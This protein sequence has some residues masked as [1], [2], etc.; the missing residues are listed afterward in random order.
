MRAYFSFFK[1][2]FLNGLQY[3][4][5]A[6]AG[7]ATQFAWGGMY[8]MLYQTFYKSNSAAAP[9]KFSQLSSYIWL[10][11]AFL[12]LF[13]TWFLD[14]DIFTLITNGNVAYELCRP[15]DLYHMWF[16]KNCG[17]RLSKTALRCFPILIVAF[18][19]PKPYKFNLPSSGVSAL[20]FILAMFLAFIVV[21]SYCM[22]V[23]IFT[24]YTI[25]PMG[26]RIALVMTADFLSGGL[27]PLP[28]LP[29]WLT[30]YLYL[31]PFAAMQ[32]V[33]FRVY[34]GQIHINEAATA[35]GLQF[36]WAVVLIFLGKFI[37][38]KALNRV[39]VQGG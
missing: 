21:V 12:A 16:S 22:L 18:L 7:I 24:F 30:K 36:I 1:I 39:I 4:T 25:S 5:A 3:R 17:I 19:L 11:Q 14:E 29:Q 15:L 27:I 26:V 28:F 31:T 8:I 35:I 37:M 9:M 13:M 20:L 38:S 10:Q 33:P 6:Y 32:N 2:R 34:S 23:Y